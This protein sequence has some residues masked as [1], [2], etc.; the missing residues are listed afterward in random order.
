[1]IALPAAPD[2]ALRAVALELAANDDMDAR[3][4]VDACEAEIVT[5]GGRVSARAWREARSAI[6]EAR[7]WKEAEESPA[8]S[9][10]TEWMPIRLGPRL[11]SV[12]FNSD[13][14]TP[15][16]A[17][18]IKGLLTR[19]GL[20]MLYGE[21]AAGKTFLA[22]HLALCVAWGLPFFGRRVKQGAVVYMAA[23]GGAS[24]LGR[25]KAAEAA[26]R[27]AINTTNLARRAKGLPALE[28]QPLHVVTEAPNLS[29]GGEPEKFVQTVKDLGLIVGAKGHRLALV[30][31]DTWHAMMAGAEENSSADTGEALKPLRELSESEGFTVLLLHHPG[32]DLERGSRGSNALPAAMDAIIAL[33]VPGHEGPKPKPSEAIRRA[34]VTKLRDG[35][36]G[37][38]LA[39]RLSVVETGRDEDG[40]PLTTCTVLPVTEEPQDREGLAPLD[41]EII[42]AFEK[43]QRDGKASVDAVRGAFYQGRPGAK[44]DA[45]KKA[46][47]RA[48]FS[49]ERAGA[50]VTDAA[51]Q[52]FSRS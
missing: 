31:G 25:M 14:E 35:E 12:E 18:L 39:Y 38:T 2:D 50:L 23:E 22:I 34:T 9:A 37:G 32:K 16:P 7:R 33:S 47:Q 52:W 51:D 36:A 26:L 11:R 1:M 13:V 44:P 20:G 6:Y 42:A 28:R 41:R 4:I 3:D 15:P 8:P 49:I 46:F 24:V 45:R 43:V 17:W 48:K 27:P 10:A 30:V 21:S 19:S 5:R 40:D 29:R